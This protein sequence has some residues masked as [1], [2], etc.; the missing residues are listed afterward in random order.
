M[1]SIDPAFLDVVQVPGVYENLRPIQEMLKEKK[2]VGD[3][4]R[5]AND[6]NISDSERG[7]R[8]SALKAL[9]LGMNEY[10]E[11]DQFSA[12]KFAEHRNKIG[13]FAGELFYYADKQ[14]DAVRDGVQLPALAQDTKPE[15]TTSPKPVA[16]K[17]SEEAKSKKA[18][19]SRI[20]PGQSSREASHKKPTIEVVESGEN[21]KKTA[22]R[23]KKEQRKHEAVYSRKK[24]EKALKEEPIELPKK[25]WKL[26][27]DKVEGE[28]RMDLEERRRWLTGVL[29]EKSKDNSPFAIERQRMLAAVRER[30]YGQNQLHSSLFSRQMN[31][32]GVR[33][34]AIDL[35]IKMSEPGVSITDV[36]DQPKN[37][38]DLKAIRLIGLALLEEGVDERGKQI[39]FDELSEESKNIV[40]AGELLGMEAESRMIQQ[41]IVAGSLDNAPRA[42]LANVYRRYRQ[43][44]KSDDL[45]EYFY[46]KFS[47]MAN[48]LERRF[49]FED[50]EIVKQRRTEQAKVEQRREARQRPPE[51]KV[52]QQ[53]KQPAT[54]PQTVQPTLEEQLPQ[55]LADQLPK[56]GEDAEYVKNFME[57]IT[58]QLG[59][60]DYVT[61]LNK[62]EYAI[63]LWGQVKYFGVK[64]HKVLI[65]KDIFGWKKGGFRQLYN[66]WGAKKAMGTVRMKVIEAIDDVSRQNPDLDLSSFR[67]RLKKANEAERVGNLDAERRAFI[68]RER[69]DNDELAAQGEHKTAGS[70]PENS[71]AEGNDILDADDVTAH[72]S[73]TEVIDSKRATPEEVE[74]A[75]FAEVQLW[76]QENQDL[77][78]NEWKVV[79]DKRQREQ[80]E[81]YAKQRNMKPKKLWNSLRSLRASKAA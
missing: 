12:K 51:V 59:Y 41:A 18:D 48:L 80:L 24:A 44:S 1:K 53:P 17:K 25:L 8:L 77:S 2:T 67:D 69:Q 22:A 47:G 10:A 28:R 39:P 46:K 56:T 54:E 20:I 73:E 33:G 13:S 16:R 11:L 62:W 79:A 63:P 32:P 49:G 50:P 74:Q 27:A 26:R 31:Q 5:W 37:S 78:Y 64:F 45:P 23:E 14:L 72:E 81:R 75:F 40:R 15:S 42:R 38:L 3:V 36:F 34:R 60:A 65:Y 52:E 58:D 35:S 76:Q 4:E 7:Q 43:F 66:P 57:N 29:N 68:E 30:L 21:W 9:A 61:G 71:Q 6:P 70:S 55:L 19:T